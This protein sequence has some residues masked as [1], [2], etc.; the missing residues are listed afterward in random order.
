PDIDLAAW[1]E[2]L[3]LI[4]AWRPRS[5]AITHFGSCDDVEAHLA[6]LR[7]RLDR[8]ELM[9]SELDEA[10]FAAA[11]RAELAGSSPETAAT[12][13]QAMPSEQSFHGLARY[14]RTREASH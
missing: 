9:A 10:G 4:E 5:L 14:L 2:S 1:R 3:E 11:V 13:A 8:L 7:E 12:Y 6:A